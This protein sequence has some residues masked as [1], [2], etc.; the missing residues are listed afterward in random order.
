MTVEPISPAAALVPLM[1]RTI[2][3][4]MG[5]DGCR[6]NGLGK[7]RRELHI[8]STRFCLGADE[9]LAL[10]CRRCGKCPEHKILG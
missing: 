6:Q 9:L 5:A 10:I 3:K 7:L 8:D 2:F 4:T 1:A